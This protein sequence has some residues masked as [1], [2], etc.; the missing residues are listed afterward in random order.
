MDFLLKLFPILLVSGVVF[1]LIAAGVIKLSDPDVGLKR[2]Y[3]Y[4]PTVAVLVSCY[5]EGAAIY[6]TIK[7]VA[8]SDYPA[9]KLRIHV[10]DDC[11]PN[12]DSWEWI[13]K[14]AVD[15]PNVVATKNEKNKGKGKTIL[16]ASRA[17]TTEVIVTID[18]DT[19]VEKR[20]IKELAACFA[21]PKMGLVGGIVGISNPNH[22]DLTAF[23]VCIYYLGFIVFKIPESYFRSV[24]CVS[25]CLSMIRTSVFNEISDEIEHRNW[26]GLPIR[27]GEDR[28]ITHQTLLHGYQTYVTDKA[29]CWTPGPDTIQGYWG[30]QLRWC[31]SAVYDFFRTLRHP[32]LHAKKVHPYTFYVLLIQ[33]MAIFLALVVYAS[34]AISVFLAGVMMRSIHYVGVVALLL[35]LIRHFKKE[36]RVHRNPLRLLV[37]AAWGLIHTLFMFPLAL[38]TLDC[39][40][41]GG[42]RDNSKKVEETKQ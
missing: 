41:W 42:H 26:F 12:P 10:F 13:Q 25:G 11:S 37:Y 19:L 6:D 8:E 33:P 1:K 2:N 28:F 31:Q 34:S 16:E 29:H 36:Q 14:C 15:F 18:S 9:D 39:D 24:A 21:E 38:T 30:Q 35:V 4:T 3:S 23:Q 5:N 40:G 22:N 20:A 32:Y 27:Y 7:S 17:A